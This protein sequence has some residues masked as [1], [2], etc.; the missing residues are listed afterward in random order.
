MTKAIGASVRSRSENTAL[1]VPWARTASARPCRSVT[2]GGSSTSTGRT[3]AAMHCTRSA[4]TGP[5]CSMLRME[6][7]GSHQEAAAAELVL[8]QLLGDLAI[9]GL[10]QRLPEEHPF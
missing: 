9:A 10:R 1:V 8:H 4:C 6:F 3:L 7:P 5:G 2:P